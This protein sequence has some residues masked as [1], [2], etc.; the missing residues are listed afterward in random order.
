MAGDLIPPPSPAP[1]TDPEADPKASAQLEE[2]VQLAA[3]AAAGGPRA[4]GRRRSAAASA[5]CSASWPVSVSARRVR[6]RCCSARRDFLIPAITHHTPVKERH[7][8]LQRFRT[9]DYPVVV[10]SRVPNEGIDVPE[11]S[12]AIVL[13]GTG[14][15]REYVQRLGR[16]LRRREGK[17]AVLYEVVAEGRVKSRSRA[18]GGKG[19]ASPQIVSSTGVRLIYSPATRGRHPCPSAPNLSR[20]TTDLPAEL[21][22]QR[23]HG[24]AV[25]PQAAARQRRHPGAGG[26]PDRR[27]SRGAGADPR[28]A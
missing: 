18:D 22:I 9:G 3:E 8:I 1:Q 28:R 12:I 14:S 19:P 7:D 26:G 21:L 4:A 10:T 5:S 11:A 15:R 27:V 25:I 24:E 6:W 2:A 16:I 17:Q 23:Y 13:S 20:R